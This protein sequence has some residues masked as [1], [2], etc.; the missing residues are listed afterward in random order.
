MFK[1]LPHTSGWLLLITAVLCKKLG[2]NG[3]TRPSVT[4]RLPGSGKDQLA[5]CLRLTLCATRA[6]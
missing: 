2:L 5:C 6:D 1:S 3:T 4:C